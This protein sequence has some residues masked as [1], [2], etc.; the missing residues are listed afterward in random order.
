[1]GTLSRMRTH[2]WPPNKSFDRG[3][4]NAGAFT[5]QVNFAVTCTKNMRR[6][7]TEI[8]ELYIKG[9]D[10]DEY[11]ILEEIYTEDAEVE[12]EIAS[13]SISFPESILGNKDIARVLSKEFNQNY[14]E[15]KTYYLSRP[16]NKLSNI[17]EQNWL[18]VMRDIKS[19]KTRV[20]TGHYNWEFLNDSK[21]L[22]IQRHKIYI[23]EMLNIEDEQMSEL[24]RIQDELNYP[25]VD[26]KKVCSVLNANIAFENITKYLK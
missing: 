4:V 25:W 12:F 23:H 5:T 8:L 16:A 17:Y 15:V 1:M 13:N 19:G 10:Q 3:T 22:K 26:K 14:Q 9:K 21:N 20:G 2:L 7:S 18:V 11:L 24:T 6:N